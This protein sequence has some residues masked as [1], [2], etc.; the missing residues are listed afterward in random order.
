MRSRAVLILCL[1][2]IVVSSS[3]Y[4]RKKPPKPSEAPPAPQMSSDDKVIHALNRLTFGARQADV[5]QVRQMGLQQWIDQQLH[6]ESLPENPVLEAKLAPLDSL[7]M[8]S[9]EL[10][11]H[12]PGPQSSRL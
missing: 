9:R 3:L 1:T 8:N 7:N 5:E 12:Y 2:L 11:Q 4:A 10:V 6:P